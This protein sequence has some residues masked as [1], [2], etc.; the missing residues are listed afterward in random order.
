MTLAGRS[1]PANITATRS[2][3]V[4]TVRT[5]THSSLLPSLRRDLVGM[6]GFEPLRHQTPEF[7]SS[8]S[9]GSAT[10]PYDCGRRRLP[11]TR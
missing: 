9:T 2:L 11:S 5:T 1:L 10:S 4:V 3:E 7:E 6:K 8:A